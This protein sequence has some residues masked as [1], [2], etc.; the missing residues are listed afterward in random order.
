MTWLNEQAKIEEKR[1]TPAVVVLESAFPAERKSKPYRFLIILGGIFIGA[2][3]AFSL[4]ILYDN[5]ISRKKQN[6]AFY[7]SLVG[8]KDIIYD[9]FM[10]LRLFIN[11]LKSI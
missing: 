10:P 1:N 8:M 2:T 7:E 3:S 11:R 4:S 9:D 6:P 5:W